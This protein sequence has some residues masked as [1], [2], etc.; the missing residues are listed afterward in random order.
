M[1]DRERL[2]QECERLL[3]ARRE[4]VARQI[5]RADRQQRWAL[6]FAGLA[7]LMGVGILAKLLG[8]M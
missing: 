8:V 3:E 6:F 1:Y 5:V 4:D 7:G 2:N